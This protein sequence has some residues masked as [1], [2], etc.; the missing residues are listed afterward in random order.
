M[1]ASNESN[2]MTCQGLQVRADEWESRA[3][4]PHG[5]SVQLRDITSEQR[6][7][8]RLSDTANAALQLGVGG[9]RV[10]PPE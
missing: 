10:I 4:G 8:I 2:L 9:A 7:P 6:Q 5:K 3:V 1:I